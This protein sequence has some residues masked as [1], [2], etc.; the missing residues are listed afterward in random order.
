LTACRF[1]YGR[2]YLARQDSVA[3]DPVELIL[4]DRTFETVALGG[5]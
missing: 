4:T 5:A 3:F 1:V 2:S